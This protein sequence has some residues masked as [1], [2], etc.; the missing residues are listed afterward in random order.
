MPKPRT[1]PSRSPK[2]RPTRPAPLSDLLTV[3]DLSPPQFHRIL[4]LAAECK[5]KPAKFS[6]LLAGKSVILIFEKPSLR[7]R[8]SFDVGVA[9]LG[10][11]PLFYPHHDQRLGERE[12]LK[13]F[14]KNLD[15]M[16]DAI[17]A[18]VFSQRALEE[19]A[20][21]SRVPVI[22][23]LS[24]EHHPCQALADLLT[25]NERFGKLK[26]LSVTYVGDGNNVTHSLMQAAALAG[27]HATVL[28]PQG[29]EPNAEIM[30]RAADV[31]KTQ[32]GS[33]RITSDIASVRDQHAI[34]TDAW[35]SMHQSGSDTKERALRPYQVNDQLMAR[36]GR[37]DAI[38]MHCLPAH[39]GEEVTA[40]VIDGP[41][42]VVYDEAENRL[43]AQ[44]AVMIE[45]MGKR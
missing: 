39:R 9:K 13:D 33:L 14:A 4:K 5:A 10:G 44:M 29:Y 2:T 7:T 18:R 30:T 37:K 1:Q 16:V 41:A 6:T 12:S 8:V 27:M 15:R 31:A 40:E 26:G 23:A 42:S 11:N 24:D 43:W 19:M 22:N 35:I 36:L 34:Y 38:F 32:G 20:E 45:L 17:V 25:I 21:H 28:S 3:F